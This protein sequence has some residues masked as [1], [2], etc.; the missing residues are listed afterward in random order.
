MDFYKVSGGGNDFI[1]LPGAAGAT[2]PAPEAVRAWCRRGISV[3]ADGLFLLSPREDEANAVTMEHYNADGGRASLCLNGARC[4]AR[5]ALALG[6][7]T[8][9]VTLHTDAGAVEAEAVPGQP[10]VIALTV[11]PPKGPPATLDFQ[12]DD[13]PSQGLFLTVGVPHLVLPWSHDLDKAPVATLGAALV[14]HPA[15]GKAGANINL[16]HYHAADQFAIRTY[17]RGVN[18]ETLACGTGVLAAAAVGVYLGSIRFPVAARTQGG[19]VLRVDGEVENGEV[20]RWR[21]IGDA[22]LVARGE[23]LPGAAPTP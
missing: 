23:I 19:F 18:A 7:A 11:P 15:V 5:L 1:A 4:A 8:G 14:H 6:W 2:P 12:V 22:R 16:V 10:D 21:L 13:T 3:G 20:R 9:T 17:E